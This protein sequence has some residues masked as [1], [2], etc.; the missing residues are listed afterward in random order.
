[1]TK[2]PGWFAP[3]AACTLLVVA[4][5]LSGCGDSGPVLVPVTG[6]I[7]KSD[8]PVVD[9]IVRFIPDTGRTANAKTTEDGTF[10]M[11]YGRGKLGVPPGSYQVVI[12]TVKPKDEP[13]EPAPSVANGI[14][15]EVVSSAPP[16][17]PTKYEYELRERIIVTEGTPPEPLSID[18]DTVEVKPE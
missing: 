7:Y 16:F 3:A 13:D 8:E 10:E 1:M 11:K 17:D 18:L 12:T 6:E 14:P 5:G 4:A 2:R 9:A 15:T